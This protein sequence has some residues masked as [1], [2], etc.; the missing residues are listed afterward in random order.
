MQARNRLHL[1][2]KMPCK[3]VENLRQQPVRINT[4][5]M[6]VPRVSAHCGCSREKTKDHHLIATSRRMYRLYQLYGT[7]V[8]P[9]PVYA[10]ADCEI[11]ATWRDSRLS[12][13][14]G[15]AGFHCASLFGY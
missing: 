2:V 1:S 6:L 13:D 8:C 3:L 11:I 7:R 14:T 5:S 4:P 10:A 9:V 15:Q 12:L